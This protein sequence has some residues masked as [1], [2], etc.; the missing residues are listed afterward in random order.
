MIWSVLP[1]HMNCTEISPNR[2]VLLN[3]FS[4]HQTLPDLSNARPDFLSGVLFDSVIRRGLW[5]HSLACSIHVDANTRL[6]VPRDD[7]V[8]PLSVVPLCWLHAGL[9]RIWFLFCSSKLVGKT[10]SFLYTSTG[11]RCNNHLITVHLLGHILSSAIASF[12]KSIFSGSLPNSR[13]QQGRTM[14]SK[15]AMPF[16]YGQ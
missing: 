9:A 12:I 5:I 4:V 2:L 13:C 8:H 6:V 16:C 7:F 14:L 3:H 11:N 15:S 10:G 1:V